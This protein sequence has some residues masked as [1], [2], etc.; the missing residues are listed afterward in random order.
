MRTSRAGNRQRIRGFSLIEL[1]VAITIV[2]LAA[3]LAVPAFSGAVDRAR[4]D[5]SARALA[6]GLKHAR[7]QAVAGQAEVALTVDVA[8]GGA[9]IGAQTLNVRLPAD[10]SLSMTT[11][12]SERSDEN[13]AS[14]RFFAD[15]SST[16]GDI[17][18]SDGG[19]S[20]LIRVDW[21]TGIVEL[22]Q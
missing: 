6:N 10:A 15:G 16:G 17:E 7:R 12:V 3:A 14:I 19:R 18:L 20:H 5:A 4:L 9:W 1:I 8:S 22:S 11:A 2:S 13:Q 21:L